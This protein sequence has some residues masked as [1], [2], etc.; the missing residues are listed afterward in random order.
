MLRRVL[1][2][3]TW[4]GYAGSTRFAQYLPS[5]AARCPSTSPTRVGNLVFCLA[6]GPALVRTLE[7][8]ET[9]MHVNWIPLR[10][11]P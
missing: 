2:L 9:R 1:D 10:S 3:S 11:N 4:V 7:R 6:F 8:F 5:R